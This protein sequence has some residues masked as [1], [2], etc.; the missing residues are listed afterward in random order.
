MCDDSVIQNPLGIYP[1]IA[2]RIS[3]LVDIECEDILL[4]S[5]HRDT[6]IGSLVEDIAAPRCRAELGLAVIDVETEL[7][8]RS[9]VPDEEALDVS[10]VGIEVDIVPCRHQ[11]ARA[12][13]GSSAEY[14]V[15]DSSSDYRLVGLLEAHS[16]LKWRGTLSSRCPQDDFTG[17]DTC[18]DIG[19]DKNLEIVVPIVCC[20][21][22]AV[23]GIFLRVSFFHCPTRIG[24]DSD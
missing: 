2:I 20:L 9:G 14:L 22:E 13:P 16:L 11:F 6:A 18:T 5:V 15:H 4:S 7:R 3:M 19:I 1:L 23:P 8:I 24:L 12:V 17:T 10:A 21:G